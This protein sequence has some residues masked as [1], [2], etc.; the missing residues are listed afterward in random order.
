MDTIKAK[1]SSR[2]FWAAF[3][4]ALAPVALAY[5]GE[6]IA[7]WDAVQASSAIVIS[8]LLAQGYTDGQSAKLKG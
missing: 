7:L 5:L 3:L 6:D 4:G 2:K 1:L 8:Y